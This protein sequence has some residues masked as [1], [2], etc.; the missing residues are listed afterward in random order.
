MKSCTG[1][2]SSSDAQPLLYFSY[3]NEHKSKHLKIYQYTCVCFKV[4]ATTACYFKTYIIVKQLLFQKYNISIN[5]LALYSF[6]GNPMLSWLVDTWQ[7]SDV[8]YAN[9]QKKMVV[10]LGFRRASLWIVQSKTLGWYAKERKGGNTP[11]RR[12]G[13]MFRLW[14]EKVLYRPQYPSNNL[15]RPAGQV[16][17]SWRFL[18]YR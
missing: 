15:G 7:M 12:L 1:T 8:T 6:C 16:R 11:S 14:W 9:C 10:R 13:G 3:W 18:L 5:I 17:Y 2:N 4:T